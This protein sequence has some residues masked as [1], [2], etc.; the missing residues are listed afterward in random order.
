[1]SKERWLPITGFEGIYEVSDTGRVRSLDRM[2]LRRTGAIENHK[3]RIITQHAAGRGYLFVSLCNDG[4]RTMAYVHRLVATEFL[5]NT[6]KSQVNHKDFNKTNNSL[7]NLEWV[8]SK[9]NMHHK[10]VA[11]PGMS[12]VDASAKMKAIYSD[13]ASKPPRIIHPKRRA[14]IVCGTVFTPPATKRA[15][16]KTCSLK[17][18]GVLS[19]IARRKPESLRASKYSMPELLDRGA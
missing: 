13:R 8:T 14:C 15:T 16:Q 11:K 12:A 18:G 10:I 9:E 5:E 6:G 3:G 19:G 4:R 2:I 7:L 1:M 17:C